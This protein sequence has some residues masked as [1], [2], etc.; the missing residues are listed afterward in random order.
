MVEELDPCADSI[1]ITGPNST[2]YMEMNEI[3]YSGPFTA[4]TTYWNGEVVGT[5]DFVT[6]NY[7]SVGDQSYTI[8]AIGDGCITI[9]NF[10][11]TVHP[12]PAIPGLTQDGN[13]LIAD[14]EGPF[15]WLLNGNPL[16]ETGAMLT[17]LE[18]GVYNVAQ[19]NGLCESLFNGGFFETIGVNEVSN[20][21]VIVYPNP[22]NDQMT[23]FTGGSPTRYDIFALDGRLVQS[24]RILSNKQ[25][26]PC[27]NIENGLYT[28]C[29]YDDSGKS[30]AQLKIIVQQ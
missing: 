8:E 24:G 11:F 18:T 13:V 2:C 25:I 19:T 23:I 6:L 21:S 9:A 7:L 12:T 27:D 5:G 17:M 10:Q 4:Y 26:V 30:G 14:G 16:E 22:C 28:V 15:I 20:L 3:Y 1:S 29:V